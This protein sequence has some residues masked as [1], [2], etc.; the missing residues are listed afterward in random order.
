ME[1]PREFAEFLHSII[2]TGNKEQ[3]NH[4]ICMYLKRHNTFEAM[5]KSVE[6]WLECHGK[7]FKYYSVEEI[8]EKLVKR[9][10]SEFSSSYGLK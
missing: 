9:I 10:I 4:K 2:N 8:E 5:K 3:I 7:E 1:S 6:E